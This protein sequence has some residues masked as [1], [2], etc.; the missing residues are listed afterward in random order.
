V[1]FDLFGRQ[2]PGV[3][4][5]P[6]QL[7]LFTVGEPSIDRTFSELRRIELADDA[8][9]DHCPGWARNHD[10]LF[11]H[12]ERV[13][14]WRTDERVMYGHTVDTPRLVAGLPNHAA[15]HPLLEEMRLV[16][17]ERYE[18]EFVRVSAALYRDGRDSVAFHGDT[19]ARDLPVATV[20]TVSLGAARR[21]LLK[22]AAGGSSIALELGGGNLC[23]MGGTC[24]RTWRHAIPKVAEAGPRIAVMFRPIW[25]EPD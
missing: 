20:A 17:S 13:V 5:R 23:V 3:T 11:E 22:P 18:E 21:F 12:L 2:D 25:E 8:W 24:Q 16:L 19:T 1:D 9:V 6:R 4:V 14:S 15:L 7:G 10:T